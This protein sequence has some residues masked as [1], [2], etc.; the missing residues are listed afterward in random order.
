MYLPIAFEIGVFCEIR[1]FILE[2]SEPALNHDV[3]CPA[4]FPIHALTDP[5]VT[6]EV[7]VFIAGELAALITVIPNSA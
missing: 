1:F 5:V 6:D 2:T 4:A 3:T 7:N